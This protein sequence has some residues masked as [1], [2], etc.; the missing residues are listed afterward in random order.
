MHVKKITIGQA[1]TTIYLILW[2]WPLTFCTHTGML[3]IIMCTKFGEPSFSPFWMMCGKTHTDRQTDGACCYTP[4][5]HCEHWL[6]GFY[7]TTLYILL[8]YIVT[9]F[10][11]SNRLL[12]NKNRKLGCC[13]GILSSEGWWEAWRPSPKG[14]SRS[15]WWSETWKEDSKR[16]PLA[17]HCFC[18]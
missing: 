10:V 5:L 1:L 9:C 12:L 2:F 8:W 13:W 15:L 11:Q 16:T 6:N 18:M 14:G 4:S 17:V 3:E 7:F